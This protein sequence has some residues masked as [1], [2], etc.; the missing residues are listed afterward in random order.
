MDN[1]A[2]P[3]TAKNS[4]DCDYKISWTFSRR[5]RNPSDFFLESKVPPNWWT[6]VGF[7]STGSMHDVDMIVSR[8]E[9][10]EY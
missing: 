2:G 5:V 10:G 3:L 4:S 9:M 7:S 8:V 1:G 6:G